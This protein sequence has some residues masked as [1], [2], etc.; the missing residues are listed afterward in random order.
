MAKLQIMDHQPAD[1]AAFD[2][3]YFGTHIPI[4][5]QAPGIRSVTFRQGLINPLVGA[6]HYY[7]S[8]KKSGVRDHEQRAGNGFAERTSTWLEDS[9]LSID[10]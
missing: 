2:A 7:E 3:Y 9:E 5:A 1:P 10:L 6:V 8:T 4:F